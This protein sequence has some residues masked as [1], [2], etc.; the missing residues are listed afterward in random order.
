VLGIFVFIRELGS[1]ESVWYLSGFW[2]SVWYLFLVSCSNSQN[3]GLGFFNN[4]SI[5][6]GFYQTKKRKKIKLNRIW[7]T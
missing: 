3:K 2:E 6:S 1:K 7:K 4:T 5:H